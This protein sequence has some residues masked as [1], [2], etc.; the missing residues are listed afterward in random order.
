M[1]LFQK[2]IASE[3]LQIVLTGQG[4]QSLKKNVKN[5]IKNLIIK[6]TMH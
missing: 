2:L 6:Q 1:Y 5:K 3:I 4:T